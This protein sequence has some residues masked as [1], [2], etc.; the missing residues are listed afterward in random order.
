MK[1]IKYF[2]ILFIM[3][4]C[5]PTVHAEE[6]VDIEYQTHVQTYGWQNWVKN[7][8]MSGTTGKAKRLEGIRIKLK[9]I[10]GHIEYQTHVQTYGWQDWVS[11]GEMSG[12][13]GKAKRLEGIR[14]RLSSNLTDTYDVYYRTHVQTYG[15][16]NW[17]KNGEM[18]GTTGQ[19]KRL[20]GI[21]I[22][23]V[24]KEKDVVISYKS[25]VAGDNWQNYVDN[26]ELSGTTGEQKSIK[27]LNIKVT[28]YSGIS[29]DVMYETYVTPHEWQGYKNS[30]TDSNDTKY[31]VE[32]IRI[33]LTG[34]LEKKYNIF[35]RVHVQSF[36]WLDWTSNGEIAGTIGFFKRLEAIEIKLENKKNNLVETGENHF[37][38][39]TT[40][41]K[42]SSHVQSYGWKDYVSQ[43]EVSGTEGE[44]K[45]LEAYK[46]NLETGMDGYISYQSYIENMGWQNAVGND[47]V[48]GTEGKAKKIEAIRVELGG[49]VGQFYD[50]Y[51]RV[52]V[53]KIG[54]MGWAKNGEKAGS[55][56]SDSRIES[57]QIK[58]IKKGLN[59][60]DSTENH[61][62][63][64]TFTG[65]K[66]KTYFGDTI[67]GFKFIDGYKYYF[68]SEGTLI[69][70][71]VKKVIDVS[72]WQPNINWDLIKQQE[73]I[74]AVVL[75]VGWGMSYNDAAGVDSTFDY[76]IRAV[77][78]LNIPYSIYIYGY[79]KADYA[80]RKEA[81]F[82]IDMMRTYNIPSNTFVWYDAE[83]DTI[84]LSTYRVVIPEFVNYMHSN[85]Y[86]NVGV[87]GSVNNFISQ[88][89]NLNDGTI[90]SYPLWI[91]QYYK[92][93][94]Y[95]GSY[96]GWQFSSSGHV[97]GINGDVDISMFYQ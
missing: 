48:S 90:R 20:E 79:A 83:I 95:P 52:H 81:Q 35:Y 66:Y 2:V 25:F 54:W 32:A 47:S 11:D 22:R 44:G 43:G 71:N 89:G 7:G 27:G 12:T 41:I 72:S 88:N 61:Y 77:Q 85:G 82:V 87:Y 75:R 64:G 76:N 16:Q 57:M 37:K 36:G 30:A 26:G 28:N 53:S 18:S 3:F 17:V 74:D 84:P 13:T 70:K 59:F 93:I 49:A 40:S 38:Q 92:K 29:G 63:T 6:N 46:I 1:Y 4:L 5:I 51:Y 67:T 34:D 91:A 10:E 86:G 45:R 15:W 19:A 65:D 23:I 24:D 8:N 94:Q 68:N 58:I 78:R 62:V 56:G 9:N 73:D 42:Y 31:N 39:T 96:K 14:I 21:E 33:K 97:D 55:V 80:A 50:I 60:D 69:G